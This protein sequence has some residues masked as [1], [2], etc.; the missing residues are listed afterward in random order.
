[1]T[2]TTEPRLLSQNSIQLRPARAT[3]KTGK[4]HN[5]VVSS[6]L[7]SSRK[8]GREQLLG[9]LLHIPSSH[10]RRLFSLSS[11]IATTFFLTLVVSLLPPIATTTA[12]RDLKDEDVASLVLAERKSRNARLYGS[13]AMLDNLGRA[14]PLEDFRREHLT[15]EHRDP[16]PSK[17]PQ[18]K[19][20]PFSPINPTMVGTEEEVH[21][22][23]HVRLTPRVL[24]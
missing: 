10:P 5:G 6:S 9:K 23:E 19:K 20:A 13:K 14:G 15:R 11:P 17:V 12:L 22:V 16:S 1:M 8:Q 4:A 24:K 7:W 21:R 18:K 2:D 3:A